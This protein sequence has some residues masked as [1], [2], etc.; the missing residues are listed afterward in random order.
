MLELIYV[1]FT[2]FELLLTVAESRLI[3]FPRD[4]LLQLPIGTL[5]ESLQQQQVIAD[6]L[7]ERYGKQRYRVGERFFDV[8]LF[9][10]CSPSIE[11]N[12]TTNDVP[13]CHLQLESEE[14]CQLISGNNLKASC[15]GC[16]QR[17]GT[18]EPI[19]SPLL[20]E[21]V[22]PHCGVSTMADTVAWRK[23]AA[24]SKVRVSLWNIFEGE[25]V[26]SDRLLELLA[27]SS[28]V[29]WHYAYVS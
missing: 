7:P 12:P 2:H 13:F 5:V 20:P 25:A 14:N 18:L 19:S 27:R 10:G 21:V 24:L 8:F 26:P 22:C 11:L 9:L 6:P 29:K 4:P 16:G 17:Y 28:G 23:T 15:K 1:Q 3:L